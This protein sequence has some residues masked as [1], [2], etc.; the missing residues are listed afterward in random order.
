MEEQ[1]RGAVISNILL[2]TAE[3]WL[4][5]DFATVGPSQRCQ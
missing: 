3:A 4:G 2:D 5:K 1:V